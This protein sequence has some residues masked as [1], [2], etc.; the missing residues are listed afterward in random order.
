MDTVICLATGTG[1]TGFST[2]SRA[3][4]QVY[5]ALSVDMIVQQAES[6]ISTRR[7]SFPHTLPYKINRVHI[8]F[9]Y[10]ID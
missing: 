5:S 8:C 6:L 4:N 3:S 9:S 7:R 2:G 1:V 10:S